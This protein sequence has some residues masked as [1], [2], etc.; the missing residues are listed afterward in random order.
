MLVLLRGLLNQCQ[1]TGAAPIRATLMMPPA[2]SRVTD[3]QGRRPYRN[4]TTRAPTSRRW[5][6]CA[7]SRSRPLLGTLE[8]EYHSHRRLGYDPVPCSRYNAAPAGHTH[9]TADSPVSSTGAVPKVSVCRLDQR[10]G[11]TGLNSVPDGAAHL[12]FKRNSWACRSIA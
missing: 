4:G 2:V 7:T 11:P 1:L 3:D 5:S 6:A 12:T 8:L 9:S 10:V